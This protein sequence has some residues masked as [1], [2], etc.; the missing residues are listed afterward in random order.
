MMLKHNGKLWE[1]QTRAKLGQK[2]LCRL[3]HQLGM[4][5]LR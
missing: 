2:H 3:Y 5:A 4:M 1:A